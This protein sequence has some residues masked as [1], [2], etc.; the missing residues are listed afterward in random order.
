MVHCRS[1]SCS[2]GKSGRFLQ[3]VQ[4][5]VDDH[6]FHVVETDGKCVSLIADMA[7]YRKVAADFYQVQKISFPGDPSKEYITHE[8]WLKQPVPNE[9]FKMFLERMWNAFDSNKD[10]QLSV[11]EHK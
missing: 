3:A 7:G 10:N 6:G 8:G 4:Q 2:S 1:D 11:C 5:F 9:E